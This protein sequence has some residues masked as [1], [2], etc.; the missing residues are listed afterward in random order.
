MNP[1]IKQ[2]VLLAAGAQGKPRIEAIRA[3][4]EKSGLLCQTVAS[5]MDRDRDVRLR[6][7]MI[8][9]AGLGV[10][11]AYL[12]G[13]TN[14][15][16]KGADSYKVEAF[17]RRVRLLAMRRGLTMTEVTRRMG[18]ASVNGLHMMLKTSNPRY[19]NLL[20][21]AKVLGVKPSELLKVLGPRDYE[22]LGKGGKR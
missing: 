22:E 3:I 2:R 16:T 7:L 8:L 4:S 5:L 9:A 21:L 19:R 1:K 17:A 6:T 13:D 10:S 11:V 20:R 14:Y 12:M 18:N 15:R